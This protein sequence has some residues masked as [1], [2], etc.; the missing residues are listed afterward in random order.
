M[1][2][3][4]G[5]WIAMLGTIPGLF[6][7]GRRS[8]RRPEE[9]RILAILPEGSDRSVLRQ[10]AD[11]AGMLLIVSDV[12]PPACPEI[13]P[14]V[15]LSREL[16]FHHWPDIIRELVRKSPRPYIVLL[17]PTVDGNLWDELQRAG[18]SD[19]LRT[20]LR[21]EEL[22][23]V[24]RRGSQLWRSLEQVRPLGEGSGDDPLSDGIED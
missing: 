7:F 20:P 22:I 5:A 24:L 1:T 12:Y 17:S 10:A 3:F 13:P 21:R 15:V 14:L 6:L 18:G 8:N 19:L 23:A 2:R 11:A 9:P 16:P 4:T